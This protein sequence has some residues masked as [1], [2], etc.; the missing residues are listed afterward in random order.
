MSDI[1]PSAQVSHSQDGRT[2]TGMGVS[3]ESLQEVMD[4]RA[5]V[6]ETTTTAQPA[7]VPAAAAADAPQP[8]QTRGQARFSEL[9]QARKDAEAKAEA[10]EKRAADLEARLNQAPVAQSSPSPVAERG[11]PSVP[12]GGASGQPQ[13]SQPTRPEPTEDE[14][15]PGLKYETY[16]AFVKDQSKWEWEQQQEAISQRVRHGIEAHTTHQAFLAHVESTRTKGR[17]AYKDFDAMLQSGPGTHVNMPHSAIQQI[18]QL[19]NSEHVQYAIMKDG[20]L[21]QELAGLA[22]TNPYAFGLRLATIAPAAPAAPPASTGNPGSATPPPPMQPVGSG[23]HTTTLSSADHAKASNYA[24]YK[25]ARAAER[26]GS[27][28]R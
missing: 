25:A 13:P 19:P 26:G 20:N 6:D 12:N 4:A 14:V 21:A 3:A 8:K 11:I 5:P 18:Y 1:D 9:T 10:A 2:L 17:S 27:R 28:R 24:A 16:G 7:P 22:A 15:G 23:S